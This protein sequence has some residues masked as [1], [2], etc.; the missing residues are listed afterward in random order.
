MDAMFLTQV[1]STA[2]AVLVIVWHWQRCIERLRAEMR[3]EF[4]A[5]RAAIRG[6]FAASRA[7]I[8]AGASP[9]G[10]NPRA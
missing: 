6:E 1:I 7:D 3:A 10:S 2:A 8:T 4:A 5:T 9:V